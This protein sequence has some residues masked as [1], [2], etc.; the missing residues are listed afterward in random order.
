M[1]HPEKKRKEKRN[2]SKIVEDTYWNGG[3]N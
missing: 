3:F 1:D 2:N